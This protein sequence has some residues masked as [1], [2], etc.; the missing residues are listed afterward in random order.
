MK[1]LPKALLLALMVGAPVQAQMDPKIVKMCMNAKDFSGCVKTLSING[2]PSNKE[3]C[4]ELRK[5]LAITK[6]RLISGTSLNQLDI[7]T[8]PLSDALAIAKSGEAKNCSQL[9]LDAQTILELVRVLRSQWQTEIEIGSNSVKQGGKVYPSPPI[10]QNIE[11]FNGLAGGSGVAIT[12]PGEL[13]G[14]SDTRRQGFDYEL[15]EWRGAW[16]M[17]CIA[18]IKSEGWCGNY[19][20]VS[21]KR[22][23]IDVITNKI[24]FVLTGV[25]PDWSKR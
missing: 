7:N 14:F 15:R 17:P 2:S 19:V 4:I 22:R 3:E 5:G 6:E 13:L 12:G 20:V 24:D 10:L 9:L 21:P 8:N 1:H 11:I 18:N 25:T 23:M 16:G